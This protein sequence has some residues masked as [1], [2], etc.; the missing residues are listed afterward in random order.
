MTV[1]S[2]PSLRWSS[3]RDCPRKAVY[4]ATKA[5]ARERTI[6]EDRQLARGR[7]VG[8]D[9]LIA[10][11]AGDTGRTI[12][13]CS[14]PDF[15]LP[16][17]HLRAADEDTADIL[18]EVQVRWELGVGHV[19]AYLRETDTVLEVLSSQHA[20]AEMIHSKLVQACG[21]ALG[22][23]ADNIALAI[24]DPATLEDE[25]VIVA[26]SS[27]LWDD[28]AGEVRERVNIVKGW[29]ETGQLPGRVCRKPG[30]AWGH[31][32]LYAAHCFEGWEPEPL[33]EID[34]GEALQLAVQL[35]HVKDKRRELA[36]SDK[37]FEKEQK[38]IQQELDPLVPA[39]EHV[40]G[41][42]VVKRS[43]RTKRTFK[44]PLAEQDSRI[45]G[46]LLDEFTSV[47]EF[48]VWDVTQT[49][50]TVAVEDDSDA[51]F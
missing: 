51:P 40:V 20:S 47:T 31:F 12:H 4:E 7:S 6:K 19:D 25:R 5:P 45:P 46:E 41:N 2:I 27:K 10:I 38:Q 1:S 11:A 37:T 50:P 15:T 21:Y 29:G 22:L 36:R 26:R 33:P 44:L 24:V 39:G 3:V 48:S 35:A 28:L 14:G 43:D 16:Y 13:V 49:G 34:N 18:A 32:C 42:Y 8:H 9:Y 30:D 17:P 23:D